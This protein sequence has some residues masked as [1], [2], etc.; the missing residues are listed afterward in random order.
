MAKIIGYFPQPL[1]GF[2]HR[3]GHLASMR[4]QKIGG[5]TLV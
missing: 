5:S 4:P 1:L 2:D 3:A